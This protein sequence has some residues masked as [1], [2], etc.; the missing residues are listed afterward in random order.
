MTRPQRRAVVLVLA[1]V[2]AVVLALTGTPTGAAPGAPGAGTP[3]TAKPRPAPDRAFLG[4][5]IARG[6]DAASGFVGSRRLRGDRVVY[7]TDPRRAAPVGGFVRARWTADFVRAGG[8]RVGRAR[9]ACA[10]HLLSYGRTQSLPRQ[11]R[12]QAAGIDVAVMHLL[13][14]RAFRHHGR[15]QVRRTARLAQ[16]A[17]IRAFAQNL[18]EDFCPLSGPYAVTL[19]VDRTSV[20]LGDEVTY[21][22]SVRSARGRPVEGARIVVTPP[23]VAPYEVRTDATGRASLAVTASS[24]GPFRTTSVTRKLPT[25]RLRFLVPRK[26]GASR[27]AVAGLEQGRAYP[28]TRTVAVRA[29]PRLSLD[30]DRPVT[31]G[32][33]FRLRYGV[34]GSYPGARAAVLQVV[35]PFTDADATCADVP[36]VRSLRTTLG[37][38]GTYRSTPLTLNRVGRYRWRVTVPADTYNQR[39]SVC[40]GG[41][42][43]TD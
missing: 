43:V 29:L 4:Y 5:R 9:T 3:P 31:R 7:R 24:A 6:T 19:G 35:G 22:V 15:A 37:G 39:V 28:R 23:T 36:V 17:T 40:G 18:V 1:V 25:T 8:G 16:G 41:F 20:D 26:R 12:L 27:V 38:D 10:A 14:G 42:R 11:R 30:P 13:Y 34:A 21:T 2:L 32:R 33:P